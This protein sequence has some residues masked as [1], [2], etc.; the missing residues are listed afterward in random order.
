MVRRSTRSAFAALATACALLSARAA[1]PASPHAAQ[2]FFADYCVKCH[3]PEKQKADR[4]FDALP[5]TVAQPDALT[6]FQDII[7][8]LNLGEM[9]PAKENQPSSAELRAVV[10]L[11]TQQVSDGRALLASTDGQTVLRRLNRREYLNTVGDLFALNMAMFDPT[12]KFPRDQTVQHMDNIGDALK[13]SG[14]LL[15]QYLEAADAVVEKALA[16]PPTPA[17]RTWRFT[18]NFQQQPELRYSHGKVHGYRMMVLYEGGHSESHE[19]A[20]GPLLAFSQGVPADGTYEIRVRAEA[21]NRKHPYDQRLFGN[22]PAAPFRL[23]VVAGNAK[24][25]ALHL[26]QPIQPQLGEA[27]VPDDQPEWLTFRVWLDRG[28]SPRFTFPNGPLAS[29]GN[30]VRVLR[31]YSKDFPAE[32]RSQTGI[33]EARAT[34][35]RYGFIPQIRI[36][37]VEIHGPLAAAQPTASHRAIFGEKPFTPERTRDVLTTFAARAYRRPATTE[38]INRLIRVFERRRTAGRTPEEAL[39]DGLKA[40]LSSPA[41]LYLADPARDT[42]A[43]SPNFDPHSPSVRRLS[44]HALATRLSYFLWSTT[45]DAELTRAADSGELLTP[46]TLVA[47]TRRLLTSPRADAFVAGLLDSWLNLRVLG[48]MAPDRGTFPRYYAQDLQPAMKRETQLFTRDLLDR[49]ASIVRFL[50]ADYTFAN[51]PLARLYGL[52]NAIPPEAAHEFRRITFPTPRRGGLLGQ[53]SVLTVSANG[54]ETSPVIR[55]VWM[56]ENILGTPPAPPPDNVPPIDPDVRGAKSMREILAKHRDNPGC[57]ECHRKIDPLGFALESFDPIGAA[58]STYA[59]NLPIDTSG[60][61]PNGQHFADIAD[62]KRLLVERKSQFARMLTD[63]ILTY[64]CGRRIESL[65]RP[66]IDAILSSTKQKDYP[67]HDLLEQIV[68]S[69]AFRSR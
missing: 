20:Y 3:G 53:G 51:R 2:K 32:L 66:A 25:G 13:T 49:N 23:G 54:I 42:S 58:R 52:E 41:F 8:Q 29:R 26:E 7:D 19:G 63:R 69:E 33:V 61:L 43:R 48:D 12:T 16:Q 68:L 4:R 21:K 36:H 6:D 64:A 45:P 18:E 28:F 44:A 22:D 5:P 46:A 40:A 15:A 50:D 31:Q 30:Y 47:H 38:E 55:G 9:P 34:V 37:E 57:V 24:V 62:L 60:E 59:K 14:Y 10:A 27:T 11:L 39:R 35:M 56:L 1:E 67:F 17:A 65:D